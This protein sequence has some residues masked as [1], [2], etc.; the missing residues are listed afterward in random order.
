MHVVARFQHLS[1]RRTCG[2]AELPPIL[3]GMLLST[4]A[5]SLR[6]LS[7]DPYAY[8]LRAPELETIVA[9]Q[10][11]TALHLHI[12]GAGMSVMDDRGE[13]FLWAARRERALA[14]LDVSYEE[15]PGITIAE[16]GLNLPR[17]RGLSA[18]RS[19]S[20]RHLAVDM[21]SGAQD[22]LRLAGRPNLQDCHLFAWASSA[23]FLIDSDSFAGCT[24]MVQLM[25]H[26][27]RGLVLQPECFDALSAL[28]TLTLTDCGL[29]AVPPVL[30]TLT[31]LRTLDLTENMHLQI[32]QAGAS[33]LRTLT[34]LRT[35]DVAKTPPTAHG[36]TSV[37]ALFGLVESFRDAGRLLR[38]NFDPDLSET[39][40]PE[41]P[42][43]GY[44]ADDHVA[45]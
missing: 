13:A 37:Q 26:Y 45:E 10:G 15:T 3:T 25:L 30:A 16:E 33:V 21:A 36:V 6:S 38:V 4:Q 27:Q 12:S 11:L 2:D 28:T 17:G 23:G 43:W 35:L 9:L 42:F 14:Q 24:R 34:E 44:I 32:D 1:L 8:G 40:Q 31:L 22:V 29:Q 5:A 18:L 39:Y 19:R 41:G 20:L 7:I